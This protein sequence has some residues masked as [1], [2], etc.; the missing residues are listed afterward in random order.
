MPTLRQIILALAIAAPYAALAQA[1]GTYTPLAPNPLLTGTLNLK[2]SGLEQYLTS[3]FQLAIGLAGVLAV[4]MIVV[5]GIKLMGGESASGKSEAKGCITN[6]IFG[7]LLAIGSWALLYTINP[8]LVSTSFFADKSTASLPPPPVATTV[9]AALPTEEGWY[10]KYQDEKG[11]KVYFKGTTK[12]VCENIRNKWIENNLLTGQPPVV[13]GECQQVTQ[14]PMSG[15]EQMARQLFAAA[16]IYANQGPCK[17]NGAGEGPCT[18]LAQLGGGITQ[19]VLN[20]ELALANPP[21]CTNSTVAKNPGPCRVVIS[22]G[23]EDGKHKTHGPGKDV[24]DLR[25]TKDLN[26]FLQANATKRAASFANYRLLY[27]NYWYTWEG[28]HWHACGGNQTS[29][30]CNNVNKSG[31]TLECTAPPSGPQICI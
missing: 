3:V 7:L 13:L 26:D 11:N 20:I 6:A 22:G 28:N 2:G 23:T 21:E 17:G 12:D 27:N 9:D 4:I 5:C 24:A 1:S 31:K 30:F 18:N 16:N 14:V 19:A 25:T 15:S 29:W 8:A 10:F